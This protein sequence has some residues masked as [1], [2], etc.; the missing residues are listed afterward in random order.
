MIDQTKVL[1]RYS[2][3]PTVSK[4][5]LAEAINDI[6]DAISKHLINHP[7]HA[8]E[9]YELILGNLKTSNE[10][11]WFS[12]SLRLGKIYLDERNFDSLERVIDELK[13]QCRDASNAY[14]LSKG[15]L[16]LEVFA[17]EI[18]MCI[19]RKEQRRMKQVFQ[20]TEKFTSV[21]EDARVVGIIKECGGKMYMTER[22]W[23]QALNQ[24]KASF[25]SMVDS[26][27]PR[28]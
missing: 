15:N 27:H 20:L 13:S 23:E 12:T 26:G 19:E 1:L 28:A 16:L 7:Q 5:Q 24:F 18:Q 25:E 17:L 4:N 9:M 10:R 11:L 22:K 2:T 21:I 3:R 14:D 8:R 6:Q